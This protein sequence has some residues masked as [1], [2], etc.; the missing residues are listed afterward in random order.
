MGKTEVIENDAAQLAKGDLVFITHT[1]D[2]SQGTDT[3]TLT[4]PDRLPALLIL[5]IIF[6]VLVVVCGG[7]QGIRGLISL[8]LSIFLILYVLLPG[9]FM[10]YRLCLE[11]F[12][13]LHLLF[14]SDR[15]SLTDSIVQRMPPLLV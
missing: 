1:I 2:S 8:L 13:L 4:D 10:E 12:L 7:K 11:A 14:S 9:I 3:Y 15:I 6:I 5:T